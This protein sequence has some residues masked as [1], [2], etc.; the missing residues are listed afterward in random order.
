MLR[1][2]Y[3][4]SNLL[5]HVSIDVFKYNTELMKIDI[6]NNILTHFSFNLGSLPLLTLVNLAYNQLVYL[7]EYAFKSFIIGNKSRTNKL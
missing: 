4:S 3:V 5:T 2:L 7:T 6:Y 1:Y